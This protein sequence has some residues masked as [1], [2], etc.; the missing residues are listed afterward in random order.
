[1]TKVKQ[2]SLVNDIINVINKIGSYTA[3]LSYRE[4]SHRPLVI[5]ACLHNIQIIGDAVNN[6]KEE[7]RQ[8]SESIPWNLL[9]GIR[10]RL[11]NENFEAEPEAVWDVVMQALPELREKLER[12]HKRLVAR[13]L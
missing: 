1:M 3:D 6:L 5:D 9:K 8:K 7:T 13:D 12:L 2:S 11:I 10:A 4:F